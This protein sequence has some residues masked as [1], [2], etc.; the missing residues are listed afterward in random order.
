MKLRTQIL[1]SAVV[2]LVA[3]PMAAAHVTVNPDRAPR[4]SFTRFD[5][6]VPTEEDVPTVMVSVQLPTGLEEVSF[7]PK[8]GWKRTVASKGRKEVVTWSGG[9]I[10]PSEFD[11]FAL[12]AELPDTPGKELVFPTLQTYANGKIVRWIEAPSSE[13]PAPRVTVEAAAS[14]TSTSA[15][16]GGDSDEDHDELAIGLAIAGLAA[17]LLA[18]GLS[19]VLRRRA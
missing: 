3:A 11:D 15:S 6:R 13:F 4:G 7:Q 10:G 9:E 1:V 18:L 14:E 16:T 8:A 12:S 17:G 19:L 2:G 5:I